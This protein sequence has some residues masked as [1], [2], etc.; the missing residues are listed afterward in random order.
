MSPNGAN[1]SS[2][3]NES[4]SRTG[5]AARRPA[6]P[7]RAE[8]RRVKL[9]KERSDWSLT[10][11][12]GADRRGRR[13]VEA[14]RVHPRVRREPDGGGVASPRGGGENTA[15]SGRGGRRRVTPARRAGVGAGGAGPGQAG[16]GAAATGA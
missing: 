9:E 15:V 11:R 12:S 1:R 13:A 2:S 5:G 3:R 6:G 14:G 16:E 10:R 8:R 7:G 4:S